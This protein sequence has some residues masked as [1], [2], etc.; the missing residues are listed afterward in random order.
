MLL[1]LF[2]ASIDF[3]GKVV[4]AAKFAL[5]LAGIDGGRR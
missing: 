1:N 4:A 2:V 5:M 3:L